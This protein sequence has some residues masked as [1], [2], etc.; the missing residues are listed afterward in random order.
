MNV[1][2][3]IFS[4]VL[5]GSAPRSAD[6]IALGSHGTKKRRRASSLLSMWE[7]TSERGSP[8]PSLRSKNTL[9]TTALSTHEPGPAS[10]SADTGPMNRSSVTASA[11]VDTSSTIIS[12]FRLSSTTSTGPSLPADLS[13]TTGSPIAVSNNASLLDTSSLPRSSLLGAGDTDFD[14]AEA[15]SV[16]GLTGDRW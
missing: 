7:S 6:V 11:S 13:S 4:A 2:Q 3:D 1:L 16:L 8:R 15:F 10:A 14:F 5:V 12:A 9:T